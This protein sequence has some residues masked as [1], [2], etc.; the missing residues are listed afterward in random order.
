MAEHPWF[1]F[2]AADFLMDEKVH[3]LPPEA[4][5]L[6]VRMWC[7]CSLEDDYSCPAVQHW[8]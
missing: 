4:Q 2:Y 3:K 5:A 7:I 6:L 8:E 1:K